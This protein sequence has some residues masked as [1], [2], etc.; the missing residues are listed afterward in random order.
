MEETLVGYLTTL[1]VTIMYSVDRMTYKCETLGG[2]RIGRGNR[3]TRR[4]PV[5]AILCTTNPTL[6]DLGSNPGRRSENLATKRLSHGESRGEV[7]KQVTN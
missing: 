2:M 1:S 6:P 4:K 3:S 7:R 5:R